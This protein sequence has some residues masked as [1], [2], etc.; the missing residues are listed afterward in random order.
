MA[1]AATEASTR[2]TRRAG[3]LRVALF[4]G[5]GIGNFGND[6]PGSH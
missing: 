2:T 5:F 4:G 3:P 1:D 6:A